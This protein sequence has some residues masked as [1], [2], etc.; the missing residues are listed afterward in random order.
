M[1]LPVTENGVT[2]PRAWFGDATEVEVRRQNGHLVV[3]AVAE[4]VSASKPEVASRA[5]EPYD[6][7]DP[8]WQLGKRTSDLPISDAAANLDKYLYGDLK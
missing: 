1:K 8:I 2:L 3:E 7:D 6:T 5:I 4:P